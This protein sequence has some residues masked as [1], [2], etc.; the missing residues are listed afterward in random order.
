MRFWNQF[1]TNLDYIFDV[2]LLR[3]TALERSF[4]A[5]SHA[6]TYACAPNKEKITKDSSC[7]KL[8]FAPDISQQ[9]NRVHNYYRE[10]KALPTVEQET[11]N[12]L[13]RQHSQNH[14]TDFNVSWAVFELYTKY[15]RN[16]Q[17]M[18]IAHLQQDAIT[19]SYGNHKISEQNPFE[20][21][22]TSTN[23]EWNPVQI[24]QILIEIK[25]CLDNVQTIQTSNNDKYHHY[26]HQNTMHPNVNSFSPS[27]K[28]V[29]DISVPYG[30]TTAIFRPSGATTTT[31]VDVGNFSQ[32]SS[33]PSQTA[34]DCL[35]TLRSYNTL[36]TEFAG[37]ETSRS[38]HH[39]YYHHHYYH[40]HPNDAQ[41]NNNNNNNTSL[42]KPSDLSAHSTALSTNDTYADSISKYKDP[43]T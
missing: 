28:I 11:M 25:R 22:F 26:H 29:G 6:M 40:Y 21:S 1:I 32:L 12:S 36:T 24:I 30:S 9:W 19:R 43:L 17:D 3:N 39:Y 33:A 4:H 8:L 31:N 14:S 38:A 37:D 15:V 34:T 42:N 10:I 35:D 16:Y 7:V 41:I 20:K 2:P 18:L 27:S 13:L 23:T 5:F